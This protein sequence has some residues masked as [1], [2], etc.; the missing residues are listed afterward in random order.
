MDPLSDGLMVEWGH[1]PS[2][3]NEP[4]SKYRGCKY[5]EY[6]LDPEYKLKKFD[7][8]HMKINSTHKNKKIFFL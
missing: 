1:K 5:L 4:S 6:E 8:I 7:W 2:H 3:A